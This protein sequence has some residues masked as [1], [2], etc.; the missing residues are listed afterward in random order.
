MIRRDSELVSVT[1]FAPLLLFGSV[2]ITAY[3]AYRLRPLMKTSA[4][5]PTVSHVYANGP[6]A[7]ALYELRRPSPSFSSLIGLMREEVRRVGGEETKSERTFLA[8]SSRS[9]REVIDSMRFRDLY[10]RYA[11][12]LR[13]ARGLMA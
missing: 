1:D 11:D 12:A 6:V 8:E 5:S 7:Q 3:M 4:A 9:R 2:A 10:M 13:E